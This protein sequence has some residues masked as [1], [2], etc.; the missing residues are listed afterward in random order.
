MKRLYLQILLKDISM[1]RK[2]A[3]EEYNDA[4]DLSYQ[5]CMECG[6]SDF[7][8]EGIETFKSFIYDTSLMNELD[9]YGAFD[10]NLLIGVIGINRKKAT[11]ITLLHPTEISSARNRKITFQSY[12][13]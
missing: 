2:L 1:I 5:V 12:D 11:Y 13:K 4:A 6:I 7:T 9:L 3:K 8:Q 10:N